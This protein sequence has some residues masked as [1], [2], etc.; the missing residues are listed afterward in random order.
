MSIADH[1]NI[2]HAKLQRNKLKNLLQ[3]RYTENTGE[4]ILLYIENQFNSVYQL[5][6]QGY[7]NILTDILN[8]GPDF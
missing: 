3:E 4:R 8:M 7:L 1:E 5:D 6:F 2:K